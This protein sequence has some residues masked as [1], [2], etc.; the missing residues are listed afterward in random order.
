MTL[1]NF[2]T[3]VKVKSE[4][5]KQKNDVPKHIQMQV[6][7]KLFPIFCS[8]VATYIQFAYEYQNSLSLLC[9]MDCFQM[10]FVG[11]KIQYFGIKIAQTFKK[12]F[13]N[14]MNVETSISVT[15]TLKAVEHS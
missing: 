6:S 11:L 15:M 3:A 13:I 9:L 12:Y 5:K 8:N 2:F 10:L 1:L 4:V 14:F 7:L